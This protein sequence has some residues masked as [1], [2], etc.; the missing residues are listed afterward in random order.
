MKPGIDL[1]MKLFQKIEDPI[2]ILQTE[3]DLLVKEVIIPTKVIVLMWEATATEITAGVIQVYK[4]QLQVQVVE[5]VRQEML[6][7]L[8]EIR[9]VLITNTILNPDQ[10]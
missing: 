1:K 5:V 3:L 6:E 2:L 4:D 10:T 9:L 7:A 8:V